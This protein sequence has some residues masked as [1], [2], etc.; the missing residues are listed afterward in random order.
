MSPITETTLSKRFWRSMAA[1]PPR[2]PSRHLAAASIAQQRGG[3]RQR[4]RLCRRFG[5][6][7]VVKLDF[8]DS[9]SLTFANTVI[10]STSTD[11]PQTITVVNA[12]N[13]ALTLPIPSSGYNPSIAANFTLN[14]N[15][16]S[17]CPVVS[18]G[19]SVPGTLAAGASCQLPIS[20]VRRQWA[21]SLA[22]WF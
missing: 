16:T 19:F 2:P 14:D 17:A 6:N 13:A 8:A 9:P 22:R 4:K 10:G 7:R 15:G 1:S 21:R 11:S 5:N 3:G 12:G 20:F 18:S